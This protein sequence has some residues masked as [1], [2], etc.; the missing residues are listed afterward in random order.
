MVV[1]VKTHIGSG[2]SSRVARHDGAFPADVDSR[3]M[4]FVGDELPV[5]VPK[6]IPISVI[7][8]DRAVVAESGAGDFD[9]PFARHPCKIADVV[10]WIEHGWKAVPPGLSSLLPRRAVATVFKIELLESR[11]MVGAFEMIDLPEAAFPVEFPCR[12]REVGEV[13]GLGHH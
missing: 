12:N 2:P 1:C 7:L 11:M 5:G 9:K 13:G 10:R 8:E 6:W 3:G 4:P